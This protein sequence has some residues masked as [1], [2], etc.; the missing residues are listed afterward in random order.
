MKVN[1]LAEDIAHQLIKLTNADVLIDDRCS[2]T[3]GFRLRQCLSWGIPYIL[4]V[5]RKAAA[6]VPK[7]EV[8]NQKTR[9][10]LELTHFE[11]INFFKSKFSISNK[12]TIS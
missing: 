9:T 5:G 12:N 8:I 11:M 7:F 4:V 3:I 2:S 10:T 6:D 1:Q